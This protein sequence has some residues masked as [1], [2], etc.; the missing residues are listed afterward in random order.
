MKLTHVPNLGCRKKKNGRG[1]KSNKI[2]VNQNFIKPFL[3]K[4]LKS[5]SLILLNRKI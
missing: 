1:A 2:R 5:I 3:S 4:I